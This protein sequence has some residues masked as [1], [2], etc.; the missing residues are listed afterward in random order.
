MELRE[1]IAGWRATSDYD[2]IIVALFSW[3]A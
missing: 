3:S 2:K 1:S